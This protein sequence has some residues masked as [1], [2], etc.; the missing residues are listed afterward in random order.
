[1]VRQVFHKVVNCLPIL[2]VLAL[3]PASAL[4]QQPV[5]THRIQAV[6]TDLRTP[7]QARQVDILLRYPDGVLM[8][9]TDFNTRN[10]LMEVTADCT[11]TEEQI[12]SILAPHALGIACYSR[13][14]ISSSA[15]L[16]LDPRTCDQLQPVR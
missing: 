16:P 12:R 5:P 11:L 6:I 14:L 15:F 1:M 9:R 7:G 2:V 8:T 4:A 3:W 10:L 13:T